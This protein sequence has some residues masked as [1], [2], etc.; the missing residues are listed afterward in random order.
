MQTALFVCALLIPWQLLTAASPTKRIIYSTRK[1][2]PSNLH[3]I[4]RIETTQIET[5]TKKIGTNC[6]DG[7]NNVKMGNLTEEPDCA[8][9][10]LKT[11]EIIKV[12]ERKL[13]CAGTD[14]VGLNGLCRRNWG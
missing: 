13:E 3:Y 2:S 5:T 10:T 14:Q 6:G 8:N 4:S 1:G 11:G 7:S 12:P 9:K